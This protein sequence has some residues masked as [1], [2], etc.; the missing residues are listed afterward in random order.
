MN[1]SNFI[2]ENENIIRLG[3]FF[4]ILV[5]M[6]VWEILAPRRELSVSKST[7]WF[8][9][10]S[11]VFLNTLVIR[12]LFPAAAV[13]MAL[14]ADSHAWGLFNKFETSSWLAIVTSVILLD[15]IIYWQHVLF[16]RIPVLWRIHRMHHAD[17]DIDVTTGSRFHPIEIIIS[18]LIKFASIIV[19]GVPVIA[20]IIFEVVLNLTAMFNHSN[21]KL[22]LGLDK[23]VRTIIVTPDMHRVHHSVK[24]KEYNNNFGFNLSLWDKLFKT[25]TAQPEA[26]HVDMIIGLMQYRDVKEAERIP[27]MLMIPFK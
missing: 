25:Y 5:I 6:A 18:M 21:A 8:S 9:N 3:F 19:L 23:V 20:V 14:Y 27:G 24:P 17:M 1:W 15:M 2:L 4:G 22:P 16:H 7:R 13:G 26:G 12:I 10:L 11:I